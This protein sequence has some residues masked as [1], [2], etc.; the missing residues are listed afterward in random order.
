MTARLQDGRPGRGRRG[1]ALIVALWVVVILSMLVGTMAFEMRIEAG[2]TSHYRKRAK[3]AWI[4]RAGAEHAR[5]LLLRSRRVDATAADTMDEDPLYLKAMLLSRGMGVHGYEQP[6]GE[7]VFRLDL[8][9][10]GSRRNV[11]RLQ[12]LE[13]RELLRQAMV[14]E[15]LWDELIDC[16]GDWI[17]RDDNTK[18]N[19]AESD[20]AF[21]RERGY[22]VKNAPIDTIDEMLLIKGF[23]EEILFGGPAPDPD[24]P[25][26]PGIAQ[27]LT[28]WGDGRINANNASFEVLM[29]IPGIAEWEADAIIEG[30]VGLDGVEGTRDDGYAS[31]DE[32]VA[33]T[34]VN[35]ALRAYFSV[36]DI[37][38][39][40]VISIGEVQGVRSGIW[41][42]FQVDGGRV[43]TVFWREEAM[44]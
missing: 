12:P 13:W 26:M 33:R 28:T 18:P 3:A 2:I 9:P 29:T 5:M 32:M 1:G 11:N 38:Y 36:R 23:T 15:D 22:T 44:P 39:V 40:R 14:P 10:E 30:R 43:H 8:I 20:D 35:P 37:R 4:A 21:Y 17:D 16:A 27:W 42:V 34:A 7:G 24:A 41:A 31:V 19:G 25:P 6:F